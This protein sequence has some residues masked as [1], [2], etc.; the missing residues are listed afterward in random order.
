VY[1]RRAGASEAR[2]AAR[3]APRGTGDFELSCADEALAAALSAELAARL[4]ARVRRPTDRNG[5]PCA[6]DRT[7][8]V[9]LAPST[10]F[11]RQVRALPRPSI[12]AVIS[13]AEAVHR[14]VSIAVTVHAGEGVAYLPVST[15]PGTGLQRAARLARLLAADYAALPAARRELEHR[16]TPLSVIAERSFARLR[17]VTQGCAPQPL[18]RVGSGSL[19]GA[20]T[21]P[22]STGTMAK[23]GG[24]RP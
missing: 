19:Y 8:D 11:L 3:V 15:A 18:A 21:T 20:S 4:E 6:G 17:R 1:V 7:A 14:L 10:G 2:V 13:D 24:S 5:T 12:V 23:Q 16:V 22:G 9:F